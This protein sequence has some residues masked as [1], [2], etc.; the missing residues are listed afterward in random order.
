V[1]CD[2]IA[3]W[4]RWLEYI[5]FGGALQRRR[6]AFFR[7]VADLQ[8]D[9]RPVLMLGEGDGRFL[10]KFV[11]PRKTP[12]K[13]RESTV[14]TPC[15]SVDY[16]DLSAEMLELAR[17]RAGTDGVAYHHADALTIPLPA[18]HYDLIVTHF[19]LDCLSEDE[20]KS[21]IEKISASVKP[22]ARWLI[23][24]FREPTM[25]TR[26]IVQILYLFFRITTGL[27]TRSLVDHHPLLTRAGFVL[28]REETERF[29]LLAS[30]LW[31][32]VRRQ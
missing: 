32:Y 14:R 8:R 4:Y 28:V 15:L 27:R 2:F 20:A 7:D 16:V 9:A 22:D 5:G 25:W 11:A 19:F 12:S 26:A 29:G 3:R 23:S 31:R 13:H 24:E 21:L 17:G 1:N 6:C 30:E 18:V 10:A